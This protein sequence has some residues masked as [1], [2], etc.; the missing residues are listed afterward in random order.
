MASGFALSAMKVTQQ[1]V[2]TFL[3]TTKEK[4]GFT[5]GANLVAEKAAKD[6]LRKSMLV[7][8]EGLLLSLELAR[9]VQK[10]EIKSLT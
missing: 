7:L 4:T 9:K 10:E 1:P 3:G 8:K 6:L 2:N 5:L